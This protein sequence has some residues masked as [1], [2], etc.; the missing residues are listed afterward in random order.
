MR[1]NRHFTVENHSPYEGIAFRQAV[2]EIR[3]PDGSIVFHQD[4]IDVPEDWSQVA[5]DVLAQKNFRKA[6]VTKALKPVAEDNVP[7]FLWRKAANG[8]E[9]TGETSAK[10]V[11][12][13][14][15]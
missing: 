5:A 15:A 1:I 13:R 11:F 4:G 6:G 14:M 8:P 10:Q 2:S 9:T 3:N 7:Q 12:D